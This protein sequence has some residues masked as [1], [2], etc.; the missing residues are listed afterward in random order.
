MPFYAH[1][2]RCILGPFWSCLCGPH[3]PWNLR[4]SVLAYLV[5]TSPIRAMFRAAAQAGGLCPL[6]LGAARAAKRRAGVLALHA[7]IRLPLFIFLSLYFYLYLPLRDPFE[8]EAK[9][10]S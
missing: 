10:Q 6:C 1:G 7:C 4:V 8:R 5:L 2:F 9:A 3:R